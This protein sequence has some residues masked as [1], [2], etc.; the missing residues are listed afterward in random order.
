MKVNKDNVLIDFYEKV[1]NPPD[2]LANCAVYI[3]SKEMIKNLKEK[4]MKHK[5]ILVQILSHHLVGK[6]N[7]YETKKIFYDIS[8]KNH[9]L[10]NE[11]NFK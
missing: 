7:I 3:F 8:T 11:K 10:K 2:N 4:Y 1:K 5:K 6:I 9:F